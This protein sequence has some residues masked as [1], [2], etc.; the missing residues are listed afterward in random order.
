M[1]VGSGVLILG[2]GVYVVGGAMA[3]AAEVEG[4]FAKVVSLPHRDEPARW[5]IGVDVECLSGL[6]SDTC[7]IHGLSRKNP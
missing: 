4:P 1:V 3:L 2:R 7:R 6:Q 5:V